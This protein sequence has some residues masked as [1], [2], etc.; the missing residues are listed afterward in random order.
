ML[1][2]MLEQWDYAVPFCAVLCCG[3]LCCAVTG[4]IVFVLCC[5][6]LCYA[7]TGAIVFGLHSACSRA[8]LAWGACYARCR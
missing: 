5:A 8:G 7:V 1:A 6:V 4:A 2:V 3:V